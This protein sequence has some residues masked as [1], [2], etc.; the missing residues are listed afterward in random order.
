MEMALWSVFL[1]LKTFRGLASG[2][3]HLRVR[4]ALAR[5]HGNGD[6]GV[7]ALVSYAHYRLASSFPY[8]GLA[9]TGVSLGVACGV[10]DDKGDARSDEGSDLNHF[11]ISRGQDE[12]FTGAGIGMGWIAMTGWDE[13][14]CCT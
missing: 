1:T 10:T 5:L 12:H 3:K 13:L 4:G 9:Y 7:S 11:S 14:Y 6:E 2:Y 8:F